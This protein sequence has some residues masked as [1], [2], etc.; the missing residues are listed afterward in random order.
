MRFLLPFGNQVADAVAKGRPALAEVSPPGQG[1][2]LPPFMFAG[3]DS[4]NSESH[5]GGAAF[6]FEAHRSYSKCDFFGQERE[7]RLLMAPFHP[8]RKLRRDPAI[9]GV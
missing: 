6:A 9:R 2:T 3:L 7:D 8:A 4:L 5:L 1:I